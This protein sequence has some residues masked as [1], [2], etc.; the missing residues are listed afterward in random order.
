M[1]IRAPVG[2][3]Y[4]LTGVS[5]GDAGRVKCEDMILLLM[6]IEFVFS[7]KSDIGI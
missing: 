6:I 1:T 4:G 2:A 7:S 3:T 5:A